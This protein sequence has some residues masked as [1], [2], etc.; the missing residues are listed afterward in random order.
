MS[1]DPLLEFVKSIDSRISSMD[2]KL[3]AALDTHGDRISS[4]EDTRS[5]QRGIMISGG[6]FVTTLSGIAAYVVN[7][8]LH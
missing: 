5:E 7:K 3:D 4:L 6:A 1:S 8:I 2:K